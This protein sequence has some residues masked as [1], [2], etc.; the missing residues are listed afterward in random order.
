MKAIKRIISIGVAI[1]LFLLTLQL[2]AES[3]KET[4]EPHGPAETAAI[5]LALHKRLPV[6]AW[7]IWPR[8]D[9]FEGAIEGDRLPKRYINKLKIWLPRVLKKDFLPYEIKQN[10]WYGIR[11]LHAC[12]DF[13]VGR[14]QNSKQNTII[15]F[16]ANGVGLVITAISEQYFSEE[17]AQ[18]TDVKIIKAVTKLLNYPEEKAQRITVEKHFEEVGKGASKILVCYG[19]LRDTGYDETK[20]ASPDGQNMR[21]WWNYIPFWITR[22]KICI[23]TTT[24]KWENYWANLD[25]IFFK[26]E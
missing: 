20:P 17:I 23:S 8:E 26:L 1:L 3:K 10:Q 14:F 16:K 24:V 22:G 11:R 2:M 21:T 19:K 7:G 15:Q 4:Y 25:G 18:M 9:K 13:V 6:Y 5:E 12:R